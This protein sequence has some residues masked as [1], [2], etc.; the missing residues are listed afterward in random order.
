MAKRCRASQGN[1]PAKSASRWSLPGIKPASVYL[2]EAAGI[3]HDSLLTGTPCRRLIA[4]SLCLLEPAICI[5]LLTRSV[6]PKRTIRT[7]RGAMQRLRLARA[8]PM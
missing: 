7:G 5:E 1:A 8:C 6:D 3:I 4:R 2:P